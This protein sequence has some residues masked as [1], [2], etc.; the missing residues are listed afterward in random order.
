[1]TGPSWLPAGSLVHLPVALLLSRGDEPSCCGL[2]AC[3]L[4]PE[5]VGALGQ[6]VPLK[7]CLGLHGWRGAELGLPRKAGNSQRDAGI[8]WTSQAAGL[9]MGWQ[10]SLT[11]KGLGP[12]SREQR[13]VGDAPFPRFPS[14]KG[15]S[16]AASLGTRM[17]PA[18]ALLPRPHL[19]PSTLPK[20]V[21]LST[22]PCAQS[23]IG[24]Q[25]W[26]RPK[27]APGCRLL[28]VN[29]EARGLWRGRGSSCN[30]SVVVE[31]KA[32][33]PA[34]SPRETLMKTPIYFH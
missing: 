14:E 28:T 12:S 22:G 16:S 31:S 21:C 30:S 18:P 11:P 2:Q 27:W 34:H 25:G 23:L 8:R 26:V 7:A 24:W 29:C 20:S 5:K 32:H 15:G 17:G 1:M 33:R 6:V 9:H 13:W 19:A 3:P 4:T 10:V